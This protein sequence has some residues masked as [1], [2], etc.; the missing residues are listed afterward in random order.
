MV[1]LF[2]VLIGVG[3]AGYTRVASPAAAPAPTPQ[4]ESQSE[5]VI[6]ASGKVLPA[7]WADLSFTAGGRITRLL[8]KEGDQVKEGQLLAEVDTTQLERA[9]VEA[10]AVLTIARANLDLARV[11]PRPEEIEA[12]R[13][14]AAVAWQQVADAEA[15]LAQARANL[16]LVRAGPTQYELDQAKIAIEQARDQLWGAQAQRDGIKGSHSSPQA[17]IDAAEAAVLQAQD[18]VRLAE[19]R[20]AQLKAGP[21]R[22]IIAVAQAAVAV[23]E[24]Q[25]ETARAAATAADARA[26][27]VELGPRPEQIAVAEAQVKQV[28]ATLE[29][30]RA[31]LQDARLVAPF[32]GVV[33]QVKARPGEVAGIS[34]GQVGGGSL[35]VPVMTIGDLAHLRIETTDLRE[36]DIARVELGQPVDV[37]FDALP[38][39]RLKGKVTRIAPMATQ[40]QGGTNY[41]VVV[42]LD[43]PDPR[44]K[45]GMTA[46]VNIT[47]AG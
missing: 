33:A 10:E 12:A 36:T 19:S 26:R 31:A 8:V 34:L 38:G 21:Q 4:P 42:E 20:Y 37:T 5:N 18:A 44:L 45:W 25:V 32:D 23:A 46:Y 43:Q 9:V 7:R 29:R 30:A 14:E 47:V 1:I 11:G 17:I 28:E 40:G 6:W 3:Y 27:L 22:E 15:A 39:V 35:V 2:V 41:T 16:V 24:K 13:Q